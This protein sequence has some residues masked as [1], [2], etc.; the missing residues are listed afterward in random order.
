MFL[1]TA[2]SSN[3]STLFLSIYRVSKTWQSL[4]HSEN[5]W[6]ALIERDYKHKSDPATFAAAILHTDPNR[7]KDTYTLLA[8]KRICMRCK[9]A[10]KDGENTPV[11]CNYHPGLLFSGGQLNGA[12][13]RFTCCSRRAHHVPTAGRDANGCKAS[14]H[15]ESLGQGDSIW[16]PQGT[17]GATLRPPSTPHQIKI[18]AANNK[19]ATRQAHSEDYGIGSMSI[20]PV[21]SA[22]PRGALEWHPNQRYGLPEVPSRWLLSSTAS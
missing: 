14:Y 12:A 1:P 18:P 17:V 6:Q 3:T 9:N 20:S 15:V 4:S 2:D 22:S 5:L 10:F 8:R 21:R 16:S 7:S 19:A 13:L 11:A